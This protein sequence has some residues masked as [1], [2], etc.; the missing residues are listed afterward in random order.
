MPHAAELVARYGYFAIFGLLML[1][2]VGPLI[3]DETIL[4]FAGIFARQ[5]KL[6]YLA[7]L[8]AG[9]AGSLCGITMS[10]L[11]GRNGLAY[12]VERVPFMRNHSKKYLDRVN[13]WF[14][15]YGRWTLFFGYFVVGVRHFT[16]LVAGTSKMRLGYFAM[17]AYTG[18]LIWVICFVSL[19]YFLGD[20][21][22]RVGLTLHWGAAVIAIAIAAGAGIWVWWKRR[23]QP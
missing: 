20:Q 14:E 11:I 2:I 7:V 9:Y 23:A 18:G 19:G 17:Y 13:Q 15:R 1:G 16:A 22:E 12:L 5:G 4:V 3:P 6:E 8:A 21:W 10:Y